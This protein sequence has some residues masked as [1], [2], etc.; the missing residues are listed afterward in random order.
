[1][2][3]QKEIEQRL[4]HL[5]AHMAPRDFALVTTLFNLAQ[6]H[7]LVMQGSPPQAVLDAF[8][9]L[10]SRVVSGILVVSGLSEAQFNGLMDETNVLLSLVNEMRNEVLASGLLASTPAAG[11]VH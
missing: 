6:Q 1:M 5:E 9:G 10:R 3:K 4:A 2:S 7:F 8:E 11:G